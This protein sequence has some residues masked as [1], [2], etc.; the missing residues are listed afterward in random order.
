MLAMRL[1]L[2]IALFLQGAAEVPWLPGH[3]GD[4]PLSLHISQFLTLLC[5]LVTGI[6]QH[7]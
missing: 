6:S 7:Q 1:D 5:A 3:I 4:V 2:M